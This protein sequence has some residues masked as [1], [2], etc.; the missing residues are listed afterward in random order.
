[1]LEAPNTQTA[2]VVRLV[3]PKSAAAW[4]GILDVEEGHRLQGIAIEISVGHLWK[5]AV[6]DSSVCGDEEAPV[7]M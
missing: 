4:V 7:L 1:M 6:N 3:A 2:Q 5:Y